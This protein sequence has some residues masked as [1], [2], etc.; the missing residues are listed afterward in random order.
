MSRTKKP[1]KNK[2]K[3][4]QCNGTG[5]VGRSSFFSSE[6]MTHYY[7]S[8]S[9]NKPSRSA[10]KTKKCKLCHGK[11]RISANLKFILSLQGI[12]FES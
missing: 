11:G 4:E 6:A 12:N 7:I 2:Y 9:H 8:Q 5:R 10:Y 3:C 1:E